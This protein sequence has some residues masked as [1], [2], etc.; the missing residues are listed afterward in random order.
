[1]S[2][3]CNFTGPALAERSRFMGSAPSI[4]SIPTDEEEEEDSNDGVII[5]A[6]AARRRPSG[7]TSSDSSDPSAHA[8]ASSST[9]ASRDARERRPSIAIK[10]IK[11]LGRVLTFR[12]AAHQL[13]KKKQRERLASKAESD[14]GAV[15]MDALVRGGRTATAAWIETV[16]DEERSGGGG[17]GGGDSND[18]GSANENRGGTT[19][20]GRQRR[21]RRVARRGSRGGSDS[22]GGATAAQPYVLP[23][24][25]DVA[26]LLALRE[27]DAV[28]AQHIGRW[29]PARVLAIEADDLQSSN[30]ENE[31]DEEDE[32]VDDDEVQTEAEGAERGEGSVG[33]GNRSSVRSR[34]RDRALRRRRVG[35][36]QRSGSAAPPASAP[37]S[38][39]Q[40]ARVIPRCITVRVIEAEPDYARSGAR[41]SA[42]RA[43][44]TPRQ[45]LPPPS[46]SHSLS[47]LPVLFFFGRH[48]T[49]GD[50]VPAF[51]DG[52][53]AACRR[54]LRG[55][56]L[57][58]ERQWR[59]GCRFT[60]LD[61]VSRATLGATKITTAGTQE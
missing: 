54:G 15:D 45:L 23:R 25:L 19:A 7:E 61:D 57:P 28:I 41:E 17:G 53:A 36:S 9:T 59:G 35:A 10:R 26:F 29:Y 47:L 24:A 46:P 21:R 18:S 13:A 44:R 55:G 14:G 32:D 43:A 8:V 51:R 50:V 11:T 3:E 31:E 48:C 37:S 39:T 6:H 30:E 60:L 22:D 16:V 5:G 12:H 38:E 34:N 56:G 4:P 33:N 2:R 40:A 27:G 1:M 42:P 52:S 49:I 58:G 20:A